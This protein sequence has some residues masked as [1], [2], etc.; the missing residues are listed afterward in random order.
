M[1]SWLRELI[2]FVSV[3]ALCVGMMGFVAVSIYMGVSIMYTWI[4]AFLISTFV[5]FWFRHLDSYK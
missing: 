5:V 1:K 3:F 2:K 4:A